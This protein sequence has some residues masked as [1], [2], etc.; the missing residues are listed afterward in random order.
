M[1]KKKG[2]GVASLPCVECE[3][4][5]LARVRDADAVCLRCDLCFCGTHIAGHLSRL[6]GVYIGGLDL[7]VCASEK[8]GRK[9]R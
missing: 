3:T 4:L 7:T 9:G 5:R 6:H 1:A 2:T 8:K